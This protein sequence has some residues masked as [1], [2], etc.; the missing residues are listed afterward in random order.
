MFNFV[1][2]KLN[3]HVSCCH[4]AAVPKSELKYQE[5]NLIIDDL[6]KD[7]KL[8]KDLANFNVERVFKTKI[9]LTHT[10][11]FIHFIVHIYFLF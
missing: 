8:C 7:L 1:I 9:V 6:Y 2:R 4:T 11:S 3:K 5:S 10:T